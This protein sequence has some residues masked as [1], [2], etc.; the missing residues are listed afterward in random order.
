MPAQPAHR[1]LVHDRPERD[2]GGSDDAVMAGEG[3]RQ[4]VRADIRQAADRAAPRLAKAALLSVFAQIPHKRRERLV[5][6]VVL[7]PFGIGFGH[8]R[9]HA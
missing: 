9:R 7:D 3:Y 5:T 4:A 8:A 2:A 1:G 6:D